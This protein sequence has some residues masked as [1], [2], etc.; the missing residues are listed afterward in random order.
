VK[1]SE[2]NK[3]VQLENVTKTFGNNGH[4]TVA[5]RNASFHVSRGELLVLVG[6][7]GSGKTTLLTLI[8]GLLEPTSGAISLFGRSIGHYTPKQLQ[9]LRARR[10]GFVFQTFLLIDSLTAQENVTLILRFA[11]KARTEAERRAHELLRQFQVGHLAKKFPPT[12][13]QGEKQRVAIARAFA[14]GPDLIIADEPTGSLE[15]RQGFEVIQLLQE[16]AKHL[17]KCVIIA[18]HD[19]RI[20]ELAD[21]VIRMEDGILSVQSNSHLKVASAQAHSHHNRGVTVPSTE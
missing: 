12:F 19:L 13:S 9:Q 20:A 5:L 7:S 18:T 11:G 3:I 10:I 15:S 21:R 17:N 8:A 1:E 16:Y 14:N 4:R 2:P 6:P